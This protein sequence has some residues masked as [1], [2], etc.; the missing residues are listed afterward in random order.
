MA[1]FNGAKKGRKPRPWSHTVANPYADGDK[2]P[3][4]RREDELTRRLRLAQWTSLGLVVITTWSLANNWR[5]SDKVHVQVRPWVVEVADT[6]QVRTVGLL[7]QAPYEQPGNAALTFVIRHWLWHLR[8][9]GDSKV[10]LGQAWE[11]AQAFTAPKLGE[12]FKQQVA[13]RYEHFK[14]GQTIQITK[15]I[16]LPLDSKARTFTCEWTELTY[17]PAGD[18]LKKKNWQATMTLQVAPPAT[19]QTQQDWRN[20]LGVMIAEVHWLELN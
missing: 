16:V 2:P 3:A 9:V 4:I 12:W 5:L 20:D 17:S 1:L 11:T 10:L 6:G 14:Q 18:L 19:L 7:P 15:P 8:T 13:D